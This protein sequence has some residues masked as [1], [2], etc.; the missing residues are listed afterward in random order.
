[1]KKILTL[2]FFL[3]LVAGL[4]FVGYHFSKI[5]EVFEG[6]VRIETTDSSGHPQIIP[7]SGITVRLYESGAIE[8]WM[9]DPLVSS[10]LNWKNYD[11]ELELLDEMVAIYQ[12]LET[13]Y[14][15]N[16]DLALQHKDR[17]NQI[18]AYS[19]ALQSPLTAATSSF[20]E[21][22]F[23]QLRLSLADSIFESAIAIYTARKD[24]FSEPIARSFFSHIESKF[25][26]M[27]PYLLKTLKDKFKTNPWDNYLNYKPRLT[28][29]EAENIIREFVQ[30]DRITYELL[31]YAVNDKAIIH[32]APEP[33]I[34]ARSDMNGKVRFEIK[35]FT[36]N[37]K[38]TSQYVIVALSASTNIHP[39]KV[40]AWMKSISIDPN[41]IL[42]EERLPFFP[43]TQQFVLSNKTATAEIGSRT[44]D[45]TSGG[46]HAPLAPLT[47][48]FGPSHESK[49]TAISLL[50]KREMNS[51]S[52][53]DEHNVLQH[54]ET[55]VHGHSSNTAHSD[56]STQLPKPNF[57]LLNHTKASTPSDHSPIHSV[58]Q[59]VV[60]TQKVAQP[61]LQIPEKKAADEFDIFQDEST[62]TT[63]VT[64][65]ELAALDKML[66]AEK[67]SEENSPAIQA[68]E[69]HGTWVNTEEQQ[70]YNFGKDGSFTFALE[71]FDVLSG[72]FTLSKS[73]SHNILNL[74]DRTDAA[75]IPALIKLVSKNEL[76]LELGIK[77]EQPPQRFSPEALLFRRIN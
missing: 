56:Q 23:Q 72:Y 30:V 44:I 37:F 38:A 19:S 65:E 9:A 53:G 32:K 66:A 71:N 31:Q 6:Y 21:Q 2:L 47:F 13:I 8:K 59:L 14:P 46:P 5:R 50:S 26:E 75:V 33:M 27:S 39:G 24:S 40:Y 18:Q 35:R 76:K 12:S 61:T 22:L 68:A 7:L 73:K 1:M 3:V 4:G 36:K 55:S 63:E 20:P 62:L 74:V 51:V 17:V 67:S 70:T 69:L 10:M 15:A 48:R 42:P 29:E 41:A 11:R 28:E 49:F 52:H 16:A 64:A 25:P 60:D 57:Q 34:I 77:Q 54:L 58:D 43:A 45:K